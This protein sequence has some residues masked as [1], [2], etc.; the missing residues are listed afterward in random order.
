MHFL[1]QCK[2]NKSGHAILMIF[3]LKWKNQYNDIC[4]KANGIISFLMRNIPTCPLP[5]KAKCFNTLVQPILEYGSCVWDPHCECDIEKI[6]KVQKRAARFVTNNYTREEGNTRI[7]M[8][9]LDWKPLQERRAQSKL[10]IFY[11]AKAG[12]LD[13]PMDHLTINT[14]KTRRGNRT[15]AIPSSNVDSHLYSFYPSVI[16]LWNQLPDDAKSS[17]SLEIFKK[18]TDNI[19]LREHY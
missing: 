16:R 3:K 8:R 9:K 14:S 19:V 17:T 2:F 5:V 11:K 1:R 7:N 15:Y 10:N 13:I 4:K 12:S 6:E 18:K